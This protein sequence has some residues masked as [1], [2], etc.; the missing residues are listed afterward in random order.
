ML[1]GDHG[2]FQTLGP[3]DQ[4]DE[5]GIYDLC[6]DLAGIY[7]QEPHVFLAKTFPDLIFI[8]ENTRRMLRRRQG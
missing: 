6:F 1:R 7:R 8:A 3:P 4:V 5:Q 2:F